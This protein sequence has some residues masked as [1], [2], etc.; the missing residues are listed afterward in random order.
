QPQQR[1]FRVEQ[2]QPDVLR[3]EYPVQAAEK[4]D[5]FQWPDP[6]A[7]L[8]QAQLHR[9]MAQRFHSGRPGKPFP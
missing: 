4:G 1:L 2:L 7:G 3:P 9:G 5:P 8:F 6:G